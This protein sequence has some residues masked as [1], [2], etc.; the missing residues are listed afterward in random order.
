TRNRRERRRL[1]GGRPRR[2]PLLALVGLARRSRGRALGLPGRFEL[3]LE[4]GDAS[5]SAV[6]AVLGVVERRLL[7]THDRPLRV[8]L[9]EERLPLGGV[10]RRRDLLP[11][12]R[13]VIERLRQLLRLVC[14]VLL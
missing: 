9:L 14:D 13:D 7:R 11:E 5:A 2:R 10:R 3:D 12:R 1:R 8:E 4:R 6:R